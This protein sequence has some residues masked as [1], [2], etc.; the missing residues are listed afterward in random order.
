MRILT[1]QAWAAMCWSG[2]YKY[3][4]ADRVEGVRQKR[5]AIL[6]TILTVM[7]LSYTASGCTLR[8]G[9]NVSNWRGS[10]HAGASDLRE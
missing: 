8:S 2:S 7:R 5:D 3:L 4:Q 9:C 10:L 1:V 6:R